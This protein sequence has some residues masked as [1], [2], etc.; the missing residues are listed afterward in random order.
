[1]EWLANKDLLYS[2]GN[3]TQYFVIIYMGKESEKE[4]MCVYLQVNQGC[5]AEIITMLGVSTV[6]QRVKNPT[7]YP[8]EYGFDPWPRWVGWGSSV[9]MSCG[10]GLKHN[11]D[12][13]LLWLWCRPTSVAPIW[14]LAW[15]L[16][17]ATGEALKSK[18]KKKKKKLIQHCKSILLLYFKTS[19]NKETRII[20]VIFMCKLIYNSY[21]GKLMSRGTFFS[22]CSYNGFQNKF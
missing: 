15:E 10:V 8:W 2:M 1:M 3:S 14:S 20:N 7:R 11:W 17:C 18:K 4:W 9:A 22:P 16:S 6:A 13:V 19:K 21:L 5:T 12:P